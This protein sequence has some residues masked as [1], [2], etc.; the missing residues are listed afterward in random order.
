MILSNLAALVVSLGLTI[1]LEYLAVL[2]LGVRCRKDLLLVL[3]VNL[4]TNPPAV[5]ISMIFAALPLSG[6]LLQLFLEIPVVIG[7]GAL[8][9]KYG[10]KIGHPWFLSLAANTVS[11]GTGLILLFL[12]GNFS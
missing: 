12:C 11:Y 9:R 8:Y 3:V 7:E 2:V 1:V 5:L 4:L 6:I 10:T